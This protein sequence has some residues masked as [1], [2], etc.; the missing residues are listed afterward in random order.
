MIWF[1]SPLFP[2]GSVLLQQT[3]GD[4]R[5]PLDVVSTLGQR[6]ELLHS[7]RVGDSALRNEVT[8]VSNLPLLEAGSFIVAHLISCY[9]RE[10]ALHGHM[11]PS[12]DVQ[13]L[14]CRLVRALDTHSF[15]KVTLGWTD[16]RAVRL[17]EDAETMLEL[18]RG[19]YLGQVSQA[20]KDC[21]GEKTMFLMKILENLKSQGEELMTVSWQAQQAY[22]YVHFYRDFIFI[23]LC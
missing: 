10:R 8:E 21:K 7:A 2:S 18:A 20:V 16:Q 13:R 19:K 14:D 6:E 22:L 1:C 11:Q 3:D 12:D 9:Q 23:A 15:Q 17:A 5:T 4:G